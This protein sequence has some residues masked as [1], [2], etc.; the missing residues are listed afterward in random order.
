MGAQV[1]GRVPWFGWQEPDGGMA[2]EKDA[3][4]V[5]SVTLALSDILRYSLNFSK[6]ASM[7]AINFFVFVS[8]KLK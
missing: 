7:L 8:A 3:P 4:E 2:L 6:A 1:P 5:Y